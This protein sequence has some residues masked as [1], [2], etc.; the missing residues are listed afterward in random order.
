MKHMG[1]QCFI[2]LLKKSQFF[3]ISHRK[4]AENI[5]PGGPGMLITKNKVCIVNFVINKQ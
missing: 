1:L 5:S 4:Q 2:I 3:V